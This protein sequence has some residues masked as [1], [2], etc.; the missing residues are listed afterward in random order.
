MVVLVVCKADRIKNQVIMHMVTVYVGGKDELISAAQNFFCQLHPDLMGLFRRDLT[1]LERLDQVAAQ[2]CPF[3]DGMA[4]GP[5]KFDIRCLGGAAVGG[6][7]QHPVR[8]FRVA[9]I[10]DGRFQC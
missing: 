2:V 10:V 6:D 3:V 9:D 7:Q 1:R 5:G 8:L 4:A